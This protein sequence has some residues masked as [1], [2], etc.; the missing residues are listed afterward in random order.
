MDICLQVMMKRNP[1]SNLSNPMMGMDAV[2]PSFEAV[3]VLVNLSAPHFTN[4]RPDFQ[5]AAGAGASLLPATQGPTKP[6]IVTSP[7]NKSF[8]SLLI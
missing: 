1:P 5:S 8:F 4:S 3:I 6:I 2:L 7:L